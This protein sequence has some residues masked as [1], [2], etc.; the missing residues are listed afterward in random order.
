M[1]TVMPEFTDEFNYNDLYDA[2]VELGD[3]VDGSLENHVQVTVSSGVYQDFLDSRPDG[4]KI[5]DTPAEVLSAVTNTGIFI[6][7]V[8]ERLMREL[9]QFKASHGCEEGEPQSDQRTVWQLAPD[10]CGHVTFM[11]AG[12]NEHTRT[13]MAQ[14]N[15]PKET[16]RSWQ[17]R[18]QQWLAEA[19]RKVM[20]QEV[21]RA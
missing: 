10:E 5:E 2:D 6:E 16:A 9:K 3:P 12:W 4:F 15:V 8:A 7:L 17:W 19:F 13:V 20:G 1:N 21:G 11:T 14:A 18:A